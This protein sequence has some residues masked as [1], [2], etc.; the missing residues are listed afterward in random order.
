MDV[1]DSI[2]VGGGPAGLSAAI[3]VARFNRTA[4]VIDSWRGRWRSHE[5]NQNYLGFPSGI[6]AKRLREL[7]RRQAEAFGVAFCRAKVKK[8]CREDGLFAAQAG[9]HVFRGRTVILATGVA[10]ILPDIGN[11]EEYWGKSLFWCIT[12]DGWKIRDG[13][14][15][16]V[17]RTD[18]AAITAMQFLNFTDRLAF[19]TNCAP[20]ECEFTHDGRRRLEQRRHS[21]SHRP[22]Q[23]RRGQRRAHGSRGAARR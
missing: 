3:Y 17:G 20:E 13:R 23:P 1:Y 10:D 19:I 14:V 21:D 2:I 7:G 11:T 15:A 8:L 12:C 16:V 9:P 6:P 18:E 22:D 5:V 4:L